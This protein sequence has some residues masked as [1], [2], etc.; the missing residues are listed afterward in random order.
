LAKGTKAALKYVGIALI[1]VSV[2]MF[3]LPYLMDTVRTGYT[4]PANPTWCAKH[5]AVVDYFWNGVDIFPG[6]LWM[7]VAGMLVLGIVLFGAS[8]AVKEK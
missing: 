7:Y 2:V 1:L 6:R 5:P 8:Y 4:C 3:I